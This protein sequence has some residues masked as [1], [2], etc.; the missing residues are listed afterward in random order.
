MSRRQLAEAE[1]WGCVPAVAAYEIE[2]IAML[3]SALRIIDLDTDDQYRK[4]L[5]IMRSGVEIATVWCSALGDDTSVC[6]LVTDDADSSIVSEAMDFME[7]ATRRARSQRI[8]H[9]PAGFGRGRR[10]ARG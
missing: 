7:M 8:A 3:D 9:A 10:A 5:K 6:F 4:R 1:V 2:Y